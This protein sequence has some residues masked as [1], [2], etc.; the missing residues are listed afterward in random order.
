MSEDFVIIATIFAILS[1]LCFFIYQS[2]RFN[3][4]DNHKSASSNNLDYAREFN[5]FLDHQ[6]TTEQDFQ[7]EQHFLVHYV[8]KNNSFKQ[9]SDCYERVE[10]YI[11]FKLNQAP[12]FINERLKA[13]YKKKYQHMRQVV[14]EKFQEK[15]NQ[16]LGTK[17]EYK[18]DRGFHIEMKSS[19]LS[20]KCLAVELLKLRS[21]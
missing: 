15:S 2:L 1:W 19:G 12:S 18:A 8:E 10:I 7:K 21:K 5:Y 16:L 13:F 3:S 4:A 11:D 9:L 14:A 6:P 17:M 20:N